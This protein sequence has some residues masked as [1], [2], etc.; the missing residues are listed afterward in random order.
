MGRNDL[1]S[2]NAQFSAWE[3]PL[4]SALT[5]TTVSECEE[6]TQSLGGLE[7]SSLALWLLHWPSTMC[8]NRM[9]E[10]RYM[11]YFFTGD[12]LIAH[13]LQRQFLK[14]GL[15]II[16]T[17]CMYL[18]AGHL[19]LMNLGFRS[20]HLADEEE[21]RRQRATPPALRNQSK[22]SIAGQGARAE[23]T[24]FGQWWKWGFKI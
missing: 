22:V 15:V 13:L 6:K 23:C 3:P 7:M 16:S 12:S 5:E 19:H 21:G 20:C 18:I 9:V 1:I 4:R 14:E 17:K 10:W 11:G 2:C 8:C 24:M